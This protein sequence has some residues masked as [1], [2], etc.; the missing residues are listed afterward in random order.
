MDVKWTCIFSLYIAHFGLFTPPE[1]VNIKFCNEKTPGYCSPHLT[2]KNE[3]S[4]DGIGPIIKKL[5]FLS[6]FGGS[7][8]L[9]P[10][11]PG[12]KRSVALN[13]V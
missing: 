11:Y 2:E 4:H 9:T 10:L 12:V 1:R 3:L 13:P 8:P 5:V 7:R 6:I